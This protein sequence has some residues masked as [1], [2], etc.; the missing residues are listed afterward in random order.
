MTGGTDADRRSMETRSGEPSEGPAVRVGIVGVGSQIMGDD[1]LGKHVV[2]ELAAG[3]VGTREDVSLTHAGT[4]AFFALEAMSGCELGIVVDAIETGDPPGTVHRYR[5]VDGGFEGPVPEI[6]LH[7]FSF[8][9]AL[10]A[11]TEAYELP[12]ELLVYGVEPA[13]VEPSLELSDPVQRAVPTLIEAIID[14][15]PADP[16]EPAAVSGHMHGTES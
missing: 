2:D 14:Q 10:Q 13:T 5:Y 7:D 11:G 6:T 15:L 8:A 4:M 12:P 16:A 3:P 1:G 9:D